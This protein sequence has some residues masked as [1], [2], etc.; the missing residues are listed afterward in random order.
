MLTVLDVPKRS[1]NILFLSE[2]LKVLNLIRKEKKDHMLRLLSSM[3]RMKLVSV[4]V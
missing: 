1:C 4:K 3:I 2:K